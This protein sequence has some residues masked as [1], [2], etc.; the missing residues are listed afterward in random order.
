MGGGAVVTCCSKRDNV[1]LRG[2]VV[3]CASHAVL[4]FCAEIKEG[5]DTRV[6]DEDVRVSSGKEKRQRSGH[7]QRG[8]KRG[9][10]RE[11]VKRRS[12]E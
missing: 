1:I 2:E 4:A 6:T 11:R 12:R 3:S 10:L 7:R 9:R 8:R 5:G